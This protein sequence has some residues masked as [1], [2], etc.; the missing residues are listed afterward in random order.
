MFF[1]HVH[2]TST[3]PLALQTVYLYWVCPDMHAFEWF[4]ELLQNLETQMCDRGEP[5]FIHHHIYLTRGWDNDQVMFLCL[6]QLANNVLVSLWDNDQVMFLR[7]SGQLASNVLVSFLYREPVV[8]WLARPTP[9]REVRGWSPVRDKDFRVRMRRPN[10]LGLVTLTSFGWCDKPRSIVC[11]HSEHQT[12]TIK[13]LQS[14]CKSQDCGNI[15]KPACTKVL[16]REN[17]MMHQ[18]QHWPVSS[19]DVTPSENRPEHWP[20]AMSIR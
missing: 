17:G 20:S 5:S 12:R 14:V 8:Q 18:W 13:I 7:L 6:G 19:Q 4:Q 10:Y 9:M 3:R 2:C 1:R 15:Q 11:T 16:K